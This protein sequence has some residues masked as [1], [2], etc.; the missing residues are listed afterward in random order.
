MTV[1]TKPIRTKRTAHGSISV[2]WGRLHNGQRVWLYS[3]RPLMHCLQNMW[4]HGSSSGDR[5]SSLQCAQMSSGSKSCGGLSV[6]Q[7]LDLGGTS[8]S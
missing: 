7:Y 2:D 4:P 3:M 5:N 6:R 1:E 8:G